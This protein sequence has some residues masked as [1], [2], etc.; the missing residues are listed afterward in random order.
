M[1]TVQRIFGLGVVSLIVIAVGCNTITEKENISIKNID[2]TRYL[3]DLDAAGV[4]IENDTLVFE[5]GYQAIYF[6]KDAAGNALIGHAI[7][8]MDIVTAD[9]YRHW[10]VQNTKNG[11]YVKAIALLEKAMA[12]NPE[13]TS[14][15]Y[16]WVLLYYYRDYEKALTVLN[17]HD[18]YTPDFDDAPMGEDIHYLKG[19]CYMQLLDY[20]KA[21]TEFDTYISNT[22]KSHGEK[23]VGIYTFVQKG[24]CLASLGESDQ[25]I[26]SFQKAISLYDKCAEAY[27]FLGQL[28]LEMGQKER[29]C[30][31]YQIA[32][33]LVEQGYKN[34]D[35]YVEYFHEIYAP[36][37]EE[38]MK[39]NCKP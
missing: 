18:D 38:I 15:Y 31:N 17:L 36:Q 22:S 37:I 1:K 14:R 27:F 35:N 2:V 20:Q 10:S 3:N 16:G 19:L 30:T 21:V 39:I 11:N 9:D 29:A 5:Y 23:F 25:A 4:D 34:E 32:L 13:E 8:R 33:Q 28:Q 24:R 12:L 7:S 6:G 26:K